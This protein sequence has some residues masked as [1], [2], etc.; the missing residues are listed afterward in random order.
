MRYSKKKQ[1]KYILHITLDP[2][3]ALV[4]PNYGKLI[5]SILSPLMQLFHLSILGYQAVSSTAEWKVTFSVTVFTHYLYLSLCQKK[6]KKRPYKLSLP[7]TERNNSPL[8]CPSPLPLLITTSSRCLAELLIHTG[9][10]TNNNV[11]LAGPE[12]ENTQARLGT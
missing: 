6:K 1:C 8:P 9:R 10:K 12:S 11:C 3:T 7:I 2:L 4:C 5:I